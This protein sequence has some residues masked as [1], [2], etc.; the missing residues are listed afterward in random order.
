MAQQQPD[1]STS[2]PVAPNPD[3]TDGAV[4][5]AN[6]RIT[7]LQDALSTARSELE[8]TTAENEKMSSVLRAARGQLEMLRE[9]LARL[10][11]PPHSYATVI[12]IN[13]TDQSVTALANGRKLELAVASNVTLDA[14][15]IGQQVRVN[16]AMMVVAVADFESFGDIRSVVDVLEDNRLVVADAHDGQR[17][18]GRA[19]ELNNAP[20]KP[21]DL[22]LVDT[23]NH[24]A[25]ELVARPGGENL[26][27]SEVPDVTYEAI[28]GLAPQI[29]MIKDAVE[30]PYVFA[31]LYAEHQLRA[32]KGVL[33]YGPPGCGKTL[34][35]KAIAHSL[36]ERAAERRGDGTPRGF[37]V[38]VKGPELLNKY[39][40]ETEREIRL[41]FSHARE[42]AADGFPVV[43]FFDEME[44]LFRTRGSG[45]SSDMETTIVPQLLAEIDGIETLRDVLI[46]GASNREDM[47]DPAILR[48]GR[49]DIK[50]RIERPD[51]EA[52]YD[53][54]TRYLT[55]DVPIATSDLP[56]FANDPDGLRASLI[57]TVVEAVYATTDDFAIIDV[58]FV[59]GRNQRL[60]LRDFVSGAM[61]E[62]VISRAKK[63]AVKRVISGGE[64][65]ITRNDLLAAVRDE[66]HEN[67][68]LPAERHPDEWARTLGQRDGRIAEIRRIRPNESDTKPGGTP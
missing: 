40:G 36:A 66:F 8:S 51:E 11:E 12:A 4:E 39:V 44:A 34:I 50:I 7:Q 6:T 48:P 60:Y 9:E 14:V 63:R 3:T 2:S 49:L 56:Q 43:M 59:D 17:I 30:L 24:L 19:G 42:K 32:P 45:V 61:L 1:G 27:L 31:E 26:F 5:R 33:L 68:D 64:R 37:F 57:T 35:A 16:E 28:G 58:V 21:G 25:F 62:S 38:S 13:L 65:G 15:T 55:S 20:V 10:A 29:E 67:K 23:K 47:I 46:I 52:A 54:L 53:I 41:L 22:V 18:I